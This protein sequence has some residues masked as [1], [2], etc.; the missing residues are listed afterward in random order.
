MLLSHC[1]VLPL[2][3]WSCKSSSQWAEGVQALSGLA[4]VPPRE[5]WSWDQSSRGSILIHLRMQTLQRATLFFYK[6][7][8]YCLQW[9][10]LVL[11][12]YL[13]KSRLLEVACSQASTWAIFSSH[14]DVKKPKVWHIAK[15][16]FSSFFLLLFVRWSSSEEK[17]KNDRRNSGG[18]LRQKISQKYSEDHSC[19]KC[20]WLWEPVFWGWIFLIFRRNFP[21]MNEDF[22]NIEEKF[23]LMNF[24]NFPN[25]PNEFS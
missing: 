25:L 2:S 21:N 12:L 20:F 9:H 6:H 4:A 16:D 10:W 5:I 17:V 23:F 1:N 22:P 3:P 24:P 11:V 13:H 8:Y 18:T 19:K 15:S 14:N 7:Y